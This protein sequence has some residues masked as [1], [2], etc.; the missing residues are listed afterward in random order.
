M[1]NVVYLSGDPS[2]PKTSHYAPADY[3]YSTMYERLDGLVKSNKDFTAVGL[4]GCTNI[5][6]TITAEGDRI[7]CEVVHPM[8]S[9]KNNVPEDGNETVVFTPFQR[10]Y[11]NRMIDVQNIKFVEKYHVILPRKST[12]NDV[13]A[14]LT[15][16]HNH[17]KIAL[18]KSKD[19]VDGIIKLAKNLEED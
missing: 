12:K 11:F 3:F 2:N 15:L 5:T 18:A 16:A 10:N 4:A 9:N 14:A 6:H 17:T 19:L 8:Y 13:S 7:C 1:Q